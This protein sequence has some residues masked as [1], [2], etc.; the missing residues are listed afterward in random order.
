MKVL[1]IGGTGKVGS[2]LVRKLHEKNV[3]VR[4]LCRNAERASALPKDVEP[5]VADLVQNS[6][7]SAEAFKGVDAVFMLNP[8]TPS[9]GVEAGLAVQY[10]RDAGVRR[11]VYQSVHGLEEMSYIPHIAAKLA[12]ER[13]ITSSGMQWTFIRPNYFFQN[14]LTAKPALEKGLYTAPVGSIGVAS[15]DTGDIAEAEANVLTETGHENQIYNLVGPAVLTG[16]SCAATWSDVLGR[17]V[18]YV[19]NVDGWRAATREF[20]PPWLN[21]SVG[22]MYKNIN[23]RGMLSEA[24]DV[25]LAETLLNRPLRTYRDFVGQ[26]A[27]T[28]GIAAK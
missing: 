16:E 3:K 6:D 23:D 28:W 1:V 26:L 13:A 9:E 17:Q 18:R 27:K 5:V 8:L 20:M 15:V 25:K 22:L 4:V 7:T 2:I 24:E 21:Y 11:F 14:D 10:A 12:V 19:G